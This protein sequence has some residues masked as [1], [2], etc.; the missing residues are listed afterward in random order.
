M[1]KK[2]QITSSEKKPPYVAKVALTMS[3]PEARYDRSGFVPLAGQNP[4]SAEVHATIRIDLAHSQ[5]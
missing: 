5:C 2:D 1:P 3:F 4:H